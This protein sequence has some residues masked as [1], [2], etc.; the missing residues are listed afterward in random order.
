MISRRLLRIKALQSLYA[1]QQS[2]DSA[3]A[4]CRQ[5]LQSSLLATYDVYVFLLELPHYLNEYLLSE[6][7]IE[8]K[9]FY[10]DKEKIRR[11][12]LLNNNTLAKTVY[13]KTLK[14]KRRY[15]TANWSDFGESFPAI[16]DWLFQQEFTTD[17]CVFDAPEPEQQL[18][19]L[20]EF[21]RYLLGECE[22]FYLTMQEVYGAWDDDENTLERELEKTLA[23][24]PENIAPGLAYSK[25]D[26]EVKMAM[27]LFDLVVANSE[28]YEDYV[29]SVTENWDPGRIAIIDLLCLKLA[30]AEF[31]SF[32]HIP[33]KVT[34]NEYLDIVREYSTPNSGRF[35]N[36]VLDKL[37]V[38]LADSGIIV[39][40][41]RG[42]RDK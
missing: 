8:R 13:D 9:K 42:L 25:D 23:S 30:L 4:Q 27:L 2:G 19:F 16:T 10:P 7:E 26:D 15:F 31:T 12:G 41:G 37:R 39:K 38:S 11:L 1:A 17:Y 40:S 21:Y 33:L 6:Q 34:I 28:K 18:T 22:P 29:K 32:P 24:Q 36:G 20:Q 35:L 5:G 14:H 3:K